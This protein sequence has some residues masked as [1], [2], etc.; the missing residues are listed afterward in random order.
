MRCPT[1]CWWVTLTLTLCV[2]AISPTYST[3]AVLYVSPNAASLGPLNWAR[4]GYG[5]IIGV[6]LF[7]T[8]GLIEWL[9]NKKHGPPAEAE[10]R[11]E[12]FDQVRQTDLC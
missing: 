3:P 6:A 9:Y 12:A 4:W 8:Y 11:E 1:W 7:A 2:L 5:C 10:C